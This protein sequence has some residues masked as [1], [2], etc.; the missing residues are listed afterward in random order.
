M[1]WLTVIKLAQKN[2]ILISDCK[3]QIYYQH[4]EVPALFACKVGR[5]WD[6]LKIGVY[7]GK[8]NTRE[9][10]IRCVKN[11]IAD[12]KEKHELFRRAMDTLGRRSRKYLELE[13]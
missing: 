6:W 4:D 11:A 8:L 10:V 2:I 5:F 9:A 3:Y 12:I 1:V 13:Q 7:K